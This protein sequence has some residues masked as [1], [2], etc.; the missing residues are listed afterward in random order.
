MYFTYGSRC[1]SSINSNMYGFVLI[2]HG[3]LFLGIIE[4]N[5]RFIL[6]NRL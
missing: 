1:V 4:L 6:E 5:M 2:T 3:K